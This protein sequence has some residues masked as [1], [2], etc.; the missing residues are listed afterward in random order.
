MIR[1]RPCTPEAC[2][3]RRARRISAFAAALT[4]AVIIVFNWSNLT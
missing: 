4:L 2:R 3:L 1:A